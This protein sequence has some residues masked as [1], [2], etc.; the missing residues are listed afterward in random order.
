M[1]VST[2]HGIIIFYM[3]LA[4]FS[5]FFMYNTPT[6]IKFISNET[7]YII[8]EEET[9]LLDTLSYIGGFFIDTLK[10]IVRMTTLQIQFTQNMEAN[11]FINFL[12]FAPLSFA[13]LWQLF[14]R[15]K[16]LIPGVG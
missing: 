5:N 6:P 12:L 16:D 8:L 14:I 3:F 4:T 15:L 11:G 7:G 13:I 2:T 10:L 1:G 9:S